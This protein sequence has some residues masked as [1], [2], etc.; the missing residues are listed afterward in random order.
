MSLQDVKFVPKG[1]PLGI[2]PAVG[3]EMFKILHD[4]KYKCWLFEFKGGTIF[5]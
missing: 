1:T 4:V 5:G 2:A 3:G